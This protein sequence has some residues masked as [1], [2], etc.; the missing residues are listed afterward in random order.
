MPDPT[1]PGTLPA[2]VNV[3]GFGESPPDQAVETPTDAGP[4]KSRRRQTGTQRPIKCSIRCTLAQVEIFDAFWLTTL[5]AGTLNFTWVS[6]RTQAAKTLRFK[7]PIPAY[8]PLGGP[9][10]QIDMNLWVL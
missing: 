1:W 5:A 2:L 9:N 6:P 10:W 4:G 3:A 7:K 8:V